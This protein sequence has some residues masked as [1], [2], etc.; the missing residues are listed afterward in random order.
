MLLV[1]VS[2]PV[3]V[4][5]VSIADMQL[6][7]VKTGDS[8]R[9]DLNTSNSNDSHYQSIFGLVTDFNKSIKDAIESLKEESHQIR[10]LF[11][12]SIQNLNHS[13]SE[14]NSDTSIQ[15]ELMMKLVYQINESREEKWEDEEVEKR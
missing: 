9:S 1:C 8:S 3:S 10:L 14:I 15:H 11:S 12:D 6:G 13:F 4:L 2:W 7:N 5:F